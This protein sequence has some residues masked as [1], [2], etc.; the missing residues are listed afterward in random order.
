[1]DKTREEFEAW[2]GDDIPNN[3]PWKK[4]SRIQFA[5]AAWQAARAQPACPHCDGTGDVHS[6][7]GEWRGVCNCEAGPAINAQSAGEAVA[8]IPPYDTF[9]KNDGDSWRDCPDDADFVDGLKVGDEYELLAG[10]KAERVT[11]RVTKAP[12][13]ESDDYEVEQV[14]PHPTAPPVQV[15]DGWLELVNNIVDCQ[16]LVDRIGASCE[17]EGQGMIYASWLEEWAETAR[18]LLAAAPQPTQQTKQVPYWLT[19]ELLRDQ[20]VAFAD[21]ALQN[22]AALGPD[23]LADSM[24]SLSAK[25]RMYNALASVRALLTAAPQP[26]GGE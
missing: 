1:M 18:T 19:W 26:K 23:K 25:P 2:W 8:P 7:D 17:F 16:E 6:P 24:D 20:L 11:F 15:P 22:P 21:G 3:G 4:D 9:S 14:T 10:W 13:D 12:G 5:W